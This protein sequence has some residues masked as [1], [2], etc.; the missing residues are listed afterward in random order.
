MT[1]PVKSRMSESCYWLNPSVQ[2]DGYLRFGKGMSFQNMVCPR[3]PDHAYREIRSSPM[4][5]VWTGGPTSDVMW[6]PYG[7]AIV[8]PSVAEA[9]E[10]EG[11]TGFHLQP[12]IFENTLG[13]RIASDLLELKFVGWGGVARPSSGIRMIEECPYCKRRVYSGYSRPEL[14]FDI[15]AWNGDDVFIIW[16]LPRYPM[17]RESLKDLFE[18][19]DFSGVKFEPLRKLPPIV[20]GTLSPG[21]PQDWFDPEQLAFIEAEIELKAQS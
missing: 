8:K 20:A 10:Q 3:N 6:S 21:N 11:L 7:D 14:I 2:G 4:R 17:A 16:P 15:D 5:L 1:R 12:V 9:M 18:R 19:C 13:D